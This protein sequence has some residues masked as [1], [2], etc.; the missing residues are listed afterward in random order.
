MPLQ[1]RV[2]EEGRDA[3][4]WGQA[5]KD[6]PPRSLPREQGP[7]DTSVSHAGLQNG[8]GTFLLS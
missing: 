1:A 8:Q 2:P 6:P 4:S 3:G 7:A 5:Q